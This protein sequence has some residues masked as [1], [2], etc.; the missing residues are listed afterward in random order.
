M[1]KNVKRAGFREQIFNTGEINLN[2]VVG[3][4]NGPALVLIPGQ[5]LSWESY[6]RSLPL[7]ADRFQ[8]YA[9]DVR[10][11][12]K[13]DWTPGKYNFQNMGQD[14]ALLLKRVVN[15]RAIVSGNSSGGLIALWLAA[16]Y[17][18][19]IDG[20]ILEDTPVFSAEWPRLRDDCWAYRLF[21]RNS[22]TIGSPNG[23]NL[24]AFF[25]TIEVP[26]EGKQKVI[27][28]P[29][30]IGG[31]LAISITIYQKLKP[32]KAVDIP[33][34]PP[35]VRLIVKCL[36]EYDPE[37]TRAFVDGSACRGFDHSEA[38]KTI[39]CPI[40]VLHANWFRNAELGLVGSMDDNDISCLRDLVPHCQYRRITSGHMIHF[41]EPREFKQAIE[42][43]ARQFIDS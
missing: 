29:Q 42:S 20:I 31:I 2:Y 8:V 28:F 35:E 33:F 4:E 27:R 24:A 1:I 7:L 26:L 41:E 9:V 17:P 3:P 22:E 21:K 37:F 19:Y 11:H 39:R 34:L 25:Q 12:G 10:G 40:L 13:S 32:G 14:I 38:L 30:W 18:A 23:R 16:N 6:Q 15:R 43:F 5:A 36:S